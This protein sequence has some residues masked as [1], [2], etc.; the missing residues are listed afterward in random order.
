MK[1]FAGFVLQER[2]APS[3]RWTLVLSLFSILLALVLLGVVFSLYGLNPLKAYQTVFQGTLTDWSGF[4]AVL[5]RT[6][7]LLLIGVG[8]VLAFR[9][10]FFN[11]GAEGQLLMGATAAAGV[12]LFV[13]MP[14]AI[15]LPVMLL[16]GFLAGAAWA[17]IPAL[18]K[19]RL[20]I[21]EV[22]TT[23][24]LNYVAI[25]LV[26][27]LIQGPWKGKTAFGY[28]Y[29]DPIKEAAWMPTLPGTNLHWGTLII[30]V[31]FAVVTAWILG[32][33]TEGFKMRILGESSSVA[34]YLGMNTLK[35]TL[36][37]MLISGGAAGLAGVGE[38]AGIHHKLLDPL[39]LSLGYGYTAI[40]VAWLARGNPLGV[41]ITAPF[42]GLIFAA[43]DVM[44]VTLQMPF[45]I[46]DV[47]NGILLFLL[48]ATEPLLRYKLVRAAPAPLPQTAKESGNGR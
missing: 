39:Q 41:L 17:F 5:Q 2:K 9:T 26:N 48:I 27:Y 10:L 38:V 29:T 22:I 43:G 36:L 32:R 30:A 21:N 1:T 40:I 31:V 8:L 14:D 25:N 23:L 47:F 13:P 28:A 19:L 24:M 18:L 45:Q 42:F 34:K 20:Q 15:T 44:K 7:P 35:T 46:V 4:S 37:V 16:V 11:I 12:G 6:I 33:T 3:N